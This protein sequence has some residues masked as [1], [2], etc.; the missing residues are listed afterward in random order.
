MQFHYDIRRD[1][2]TVTQ[3][4]Y[5]TDKLGF[6]F[7][8]M[9]INF[10]RYCKKGGVSDFYFEFMRYFK[11]A[12]WKTKDINITIQYD[13]GSDPIKQVWLVGLNLSNINY[14][15]FNMSTEFLLKKEYKLNVNWQYTFVWYA[16]F[17]QGK[18]IFNGFFD[19]WINDVKNSNWP[20]FDP[21]F[22]RTKYSFQAEPQI[23]WLFTP[24][25]KVGSEI[26]IGKGFLGSVTG[27]LAQEQSYKYDR[28]YFMPT[29]FIQYNF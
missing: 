21:E 6:T 29:L 28:W 19:Y 26:E 1:H 9:D 10:D 17:L 2:P 14:G 23:G 8:F 16:E 20:A 18:L 25:W 22:A 27:K 12:S 11:L 7:F 13:D 5:A 15:P 24:H 3:E 4:V